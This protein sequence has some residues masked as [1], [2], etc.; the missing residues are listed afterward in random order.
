MAIAVNE[1]VAFSNTDENAP[2]TQGAGLQVTT[3]SSGTIVNFIVQ[4]GVATGYFR[5]KDNAGNTRATI[6][7]A[8]GQFETVLGYSVGGGGQATSINGTGLDLINTGGVVWRTGVSGAIDTGIIRGQAGVPMV[9][10]GST[11][12]GWMEFRQVADIGTPDTNCAGIGAED[13]SGTA[14]LIGVDEAGNE[15]QLTPHAADGPSAIYDDTPGAEHVIRS[16]NRYTGRVTFLNLD[17]LAK[18]VESGQPAICRL[19]ESLD[20]W[21][22]R[23]GKAKTKLDWESVNA[24]KPKPEFLKAK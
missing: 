19:E 16:I 21:N 11:G 17:R 12:G 23:T 20:D 14:E 15:T 3:Q 24:S 22:A 8:A 5:F 2:T 18:A 4:G 6:D 9:T 13:V 7:M 10:N 1:L